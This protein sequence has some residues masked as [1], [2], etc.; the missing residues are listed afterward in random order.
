MNMWWIMVSPIE[1]Y[2]DS[3]ELTYFWHIAFN[4]NCFRCKD[5]I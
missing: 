2:Y 4:F 1:T 5:T 3:K